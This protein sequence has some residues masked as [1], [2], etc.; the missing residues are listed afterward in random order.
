MCVGIGVNAAHRR[1]ALEALG[2]YMLSHGL[3]LLGPPQEIDSIPRDL[4]QVASLRAFRSAR[5][6]YSII[7]TVY[8]DLQ[9]S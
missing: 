6:P 7:A 3:R 1:L 9:Y 4:Y 8:E 5:S 2:N